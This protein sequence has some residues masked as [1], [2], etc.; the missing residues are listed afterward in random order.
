MAADMFMWLEGG[1]PPCEG[2][3]TDKE[4]AGKKAFEIQSFSIGANNMADVTSRGG[5][6]GTNRVSISDF[7]ITRPVDKTS[8]VMVRHCCQGSHF[9][10]GTVCMRKASGQA[11]KPIT[12]LK[13]E[14]EKVFVSG[15]S[16]S[17]GGEVPNESISFSFLKMRVTYIPQKADG[18]PGTQVAAGWDLETNDKW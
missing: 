15:I 4:Y 7:N 13:Y 18:T 17:G 5:G 16:Q 6:G 8:P 10:K 12:Y 9:D 2:E 11:G 14:F 1:D 3:S